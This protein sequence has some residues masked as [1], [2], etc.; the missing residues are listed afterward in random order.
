[1]AVDMIARARTPG[2]EEVDRVA[3]AGGQDVDH[4][5]ERQQQTGISEA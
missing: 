2:S 1:M 4:G 3:V 5:E